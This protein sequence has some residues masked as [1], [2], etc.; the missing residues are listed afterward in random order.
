MYTKMTTTNTLSKLFHIIL[1]VITSFIFH[2]NNIRVALVVAAA[3]DDN[4]RN[5]T[6]QSTTT[7]AA[8]SQ[9][10]NDGFV[11]IDWIRKNGGYI[12]DRLIIRNK[13]PDDPTSYRGIFTTQN[14]EEDED[15]CFVPWNTIISAGKS[16]HEEND[17]EGSS[18][19]Y[20]ASIVD[21]VFHL[22]HEMKY[23]NDSHYTPYINL[24]RTQTISSPSSWS[25]NG[26]EYF[27]SM[28]KNIFPKH[29][30]YQHFEWFVTHFGGLDSELMKAFLTVTTRAMQGNVGSQW[31]LVPILDLQNHHSDEQLINTA[32]FAESGVGF[33]IRSTKFIPA[34]SELYTHYWGDYTNFFFEEFGFVEDY[35]RRWKFDLKLSDDSVGDN[36]EDISETTTIDVRISRRNDDERIEN[37][38]F[39]FEWL[40]NIPSNNKPMVARFLSDEL[41]RLQKMEQE[42]LD[43]GNN[44][45]EEENVLIWK[46]HQ[47]LVVAMKQ[48]LLDL[49]KD[50]MEEK[51]EQEGIKN[52]YLEDIKGDHDSSCLNLPHISQY[53]KEQQ[54]HSTLL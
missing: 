29:R 40:G 53:I 11:L 33:E 7:T 31:L 35:P 43:R 30:Y 47:A 5:D 13:D 36:D 27:E 15:L 25:L 37:E 12:D 17:G 50:D 28:I 48:I 8:T 10:V 16:N 34:G 6:H 9:T 45:P 1:L 32:R 46:Y 20:D 49:S 44:V 22:V 19:Q 52:V 18:S 23:G 14:I 21:T 51:G 4:G 26:R 24:L 2:N 39:D 38:D 3:D 42:Y 41:R 54:F